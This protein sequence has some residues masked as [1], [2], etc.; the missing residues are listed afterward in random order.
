MTDLE[1]INS[2]CK[3]IKIRHNSGD[4]EFV[5]IDGTGR[6]EDSRNVN[7]LMLPILLYKYKHTDPNKAYHFW[8]VV[9]T[10]EE[11]L[12][13]ILRYV[14]PFHSIEKIVKTG[15]ISWYRIPISL[16]VYLPNEE[17]AKIVT[18]VL[19]GTSHN[20]EEIWL[21]EK[22]SNGKRFA[23]YLND[24]NSGKTK[25][26]HLSYVPSLLLTYNIKIDAHINNWYIEDERL[27]FEFDVE[28]TNFKITQIKQY[29][30]TGTDS[31]SPIDWL[32][33]TFG[34]K[35]ITS[36]LLVDT[37][38]NPKSRQA[39]LLGMIPEGYE[40]TP[41]SPYVTDCMW[42]IVDHLSYDSEVDTVF[43]L[44]G[45]YDDFAN[46]TETDLY[47]EFKA[48][49][50]TVNGVPEKGREGIDWLDSIRDYEDILG[51]LFVLE[52]YKDELQ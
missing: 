2:V 26:F 23:K 5:R 50:N 9:D 12:K 52:Y 21:P 16:I 48:R 4:V 25:Q 35:S 20:Y 11:Q 19:G 15:N 36:Q 49:V 47:L 39:E 34:G 8:D 51:L 31:T 3:N 45:I 24:L 37:I 28:F 41:S 43:S 13:K 14:E 42:G 18:D 6:W 1:K 30:R 17:P 22:Y 32:K 38:G 29:N 10:I 40:W 27:R 44:G 7:D 33:E 46:V